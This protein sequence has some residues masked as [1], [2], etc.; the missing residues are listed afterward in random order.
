MNYKE[1]NIDKNEVYNFS[2]GAPVPHPLAIRECACG[3]GN[4]FQPRRRDQ[5]FINKQHADYAYNNG[6]RKESSRIKKKEEAILAKNDMILHK[7]FLCEKSS[8]EVI[9]YFDVLKADGFKFEYNI[10][11][12]E[13][14]GVLYYFTYRYCYTIIKLDPKQVKIL[15]R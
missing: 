10:G 1:L 5:I 11:S 4:S 15:R 3:C 13:Y 7:H 6:K 12:D 8:K 14:E 2:S 9:R